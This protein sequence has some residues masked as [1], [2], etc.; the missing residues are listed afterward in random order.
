MND[1][2]QR[3][4]KANP[5]GSITDVHGIAVGH[6]TDLDGGTGCTVV[7]CERGAVAGVDVRGASPGTRETDLLAPTTTVDRVQ[8][9]VLGGGSAFGLRAAEGVVDY[10]SERGSGH[11]APGARVP[12]VPAAILFDL[13]LCVPTVPGPEH[14]YR[15]CK[16]ASRQRPEEG[17][18]GAG[19]GATVAKALG[20]DRAVKGGV[21]TAALRLC[22]G[23]AVGAIVA[24]NAIGGVHDPESG[25]MIA[26]PRRLDG[27]GMLD[28]VQSILAPD[29][30][31]PSM[32]AG[33]NTTIGVVATDA[34]L[35]KAQAARLASAAHDGLAIAVRPAHTVHDG[36]AFFALATGRA[37]SG[38]VAPARLDCLTAAAAI[39]MAEAV[40]R[41]VGQAIGLGGVPALSELNGEVDYPRLKHG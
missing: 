5:A 25:R 3:Y 14:A 31:P 36:D 37:Q 22:D 7:L 24:T 26:G 2:E 20:R 40:V 12:L 28:A 39:C 38:G 41:S 29:W 27:T 19:T 32:P 13:N 15:A 16:S 10:L 4:A 8:A 30:A 11:Q 35:T 17:T 1:L 23:T 18:V 9:I 6:Y 34:T 21:G 33:A